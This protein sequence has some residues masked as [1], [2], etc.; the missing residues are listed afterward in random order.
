MLDGGCN[1]WYVDSRSGKLTLI[2]PD[3]A[4]DFRARNGHF[5]GEGFLSCGVDGAERP[6]VNAQSS[7]LPAQ[8]S[9][10]ARPAL[11]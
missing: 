3:Y 7:E 6:L 11:V 10:D 2:W 8:P 4:Y 9:S 5:T 1:S